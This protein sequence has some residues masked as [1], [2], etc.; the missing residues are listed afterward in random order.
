MLYHKELQGSKFYVCLGS[1]LVHVL[2]NAGFRV[3][4]TLHN[5]EIEGLELLCWEVMS[6]HSER[7]WTGPPEDGQT[8]FSW[9][10]T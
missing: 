5:Q 2:A 6:S 3:A 1:Q 10:P 9:R 4:S 8:L 7:D